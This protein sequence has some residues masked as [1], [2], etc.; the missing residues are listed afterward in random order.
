MNN[1]GWFSSATP[2]HNLAKK[3]IIKK[4]TTKLRRQEEEALIRRKAHPIKHTT[5]Y[6]KEMEA[7]QWCFV[8]IPKVG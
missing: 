7:D 2:L 8:K 3:I 6:R 1:L 4:K 5:L